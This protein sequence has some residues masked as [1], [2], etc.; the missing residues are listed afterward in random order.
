MDNKIRPGQ[1]PFLL[2]VASLPFPAVFQFRSSYAIFQ[3]SDLLFLAAGASW[4][5]AWATGRRALVR[6][7]LYLFLAA[8]GISVVL[9]TVASAD[10]ARSS[11]KLIGKFYLIGIAFLALNSITSIEELKRC[12]QAWLVGAGAAIVLSLAGIILFYAGWTDPSRN[13]VLHPIFGS[14]PPGNYPRIEGLF[15][16]PAMF[17][18]FLGVTWMYVILLASAGWLKPR[19]FRLYSIG[20]LIANAFTLTPGLGGIFIS[21]AYLLRR[22]LSARQ[23]LILGRVV[24]ASGVFI[25]AIFFAA[26]AVTLFSYDPGGTGVPALNGEI[27]PS[28]RAIAWRTAFETFLQDPILG[29][30]VGLPTA[31]SRFTDPSGRRQLLVDAHNTYISLLGETGLIGFFGFMGL[32]GFLTVG[33]TRWKPEGELQGMIK[34]CLLLA[35]C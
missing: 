31:N 8:Y 6:S 11:V 25:A 22:K 4:A 5:F 3:L 2:F 19:A 26:A 18:N 15:F 28:H 12:L 34:I 10:P 30:G 35:L 33:L 27:S 24:M 17:C 13:I 21:T 23:K 16:Y 14:L 32:V 9:S 29:Y 1:W 20:L 7:W